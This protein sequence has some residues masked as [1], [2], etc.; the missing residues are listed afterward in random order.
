MITTEL[1][2][3]IVRKS[4]GDPINSQ[5]VLDN[6]FYPNPCNVLSIQNDI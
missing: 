1:T 4:G 2:L 5:R 3:A 6:A